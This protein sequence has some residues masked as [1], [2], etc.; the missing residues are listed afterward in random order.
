MH[1]DYSDEF[2]DHF[3]TWKSQDFMWREFQGENMS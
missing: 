3:N 1:M 2:D